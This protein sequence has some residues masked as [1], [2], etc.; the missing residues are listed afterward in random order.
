MRAVDFEAGHVLETDDEAMCEAFGPVFGTDVG[1]PLE[2]GD[3]VDFSLEG[4]E[5][6]LDVLDLSGSGFFF[7]LETNDVSK[8]RSGFGFSGGSFFVM[9]GHGENGD[10]GG[11]R[12]DDFFHEVVV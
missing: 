5:F 4:G 1:A 8:R 9:V 6:L 2:S 10:E 7:E 12:D 11:E 3:G